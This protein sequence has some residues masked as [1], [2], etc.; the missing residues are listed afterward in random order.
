MAKERGSPRDLSAPGLNLEKM[1]AHD[2]L[3][4]LMDDSEKGWMVEWQGPVPPYVHSID[5]MRT[6]HKWFIRIEPKHDPRASVPYHRD[7]K[8]V[9]VTAEL[10]HR[11]RN[12][13]EAIAYALRKHGAELEARYLGEVLCH[14]VRAMPLRKAQIN[15]IRG[16]MD[17]SYS[18]GDWLYCSREAQLV[19]RWVAE[20][21]LAGRQQGEVRQK[22]R[23]MQETARGMLSGNPR[24][25]FIYRQT[26]Y[27]LD[28]D[29]PPII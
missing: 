13:C 15:F 1:V 3:V 29:Y 14:D 27:H 28:P 19:C 12:H 20:E 24:I 23:M 21:L 7:C 8:E 11:N 6:L 10:K 25:Y 9:Y 17:D 18:R 16:I 26:S 4:R 2:A 22:F 5:Y